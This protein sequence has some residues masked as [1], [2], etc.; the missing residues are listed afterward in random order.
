MVRK[1]DIQNE[2]IYSDVIIV[3]SKDRRN[4]DMPRREFHTTLDEDTIA[5]LR[6]CA[7]AMNTTINEILEREVLINLPTAEELKKIRRER[8]MQARK[9][10]M[11]L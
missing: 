2:C 4:K 5:H 10:I 9:K 11:S 6:E 3:I 1:C 8:V 7:R